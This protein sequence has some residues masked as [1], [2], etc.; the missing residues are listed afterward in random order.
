ME[1]TNKIPQL[2]DIVKVYYP[3]K[4]SW[5]GTYE[6]NH[7]FGIVVRVPKD[8]EKIRLKHSYENHELHEVN[9]FLGHN[10]IYFVE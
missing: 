4:K 3:Q 6:P 10:K 7:E 5:D 2:G 1:F 8:D 9:W